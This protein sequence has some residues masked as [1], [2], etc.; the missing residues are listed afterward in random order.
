[1]KLVS[2][3]RKELN[4]K[5]CDLAQQVGIDSSLMSRIISG[6]RH[7]TLPQLKKIS[8]AVGLDYYELLK[9]FLSNQVVDLL[10]SYPTVA[11]DVIAAAEE[12]IAYLTGKEKFKVIELDQQVTKLLNEADQL[13]K[14][15][16]SKKPLDGLQ[17]QKMQEFFHTA[18]T[19]ES[20]RIEGNTLTLSETHL[21]INDGITIGGK[22][23]REHL[24]LIN[25]KEAIDLVQDF[26]KN[27][28]HF[29]AFYLKQ[30]HQLVLKGVDKK[31]AGVY[32]SVPVRI[33]GSA[34]FP[35]EP[36][37]IDKLMEDYFLFY[38]MQK[39]VLHP[40]VLA[41]EM[42]ERLVSIH[43]FIDG[44]GRTSRLVMN[45]ILL[46]HGYTL[47]NL[48]GDPDQ[49]ENYFKALEAVQVNHE[50]KHFH[51]LIAECAI[52]SLQEHVHLAG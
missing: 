5:I 21:V 32:R 49:K 20:N 52:S 25:H 30:I 6:K 44:N 12:R 18:Y 45:L 19:Y 31:N 8:E 35:P 33:S 41:A 51:K 9:E 1:M 22:S 36:Y 4:L 47:V 7:P 23:M 28:I 24:E 17:V 39:K 50:N 13:H 3:K 10:S 2:A 11:E 29:N 15:W 26:V 43:P 34:H 27:K 48:K 42:H 38:E 46:Q 37:K 40:I 16:Q 14:K